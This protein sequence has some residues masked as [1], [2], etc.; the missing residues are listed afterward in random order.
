MSDTTGATGAA[1]SA[2]DLLSGATTGTTTTDGGE[3]TT[4]TDTT[5]TTAATTATKEAPTW[6]DNIDD[7]ELKGWAQNKGYREVKDLAVAHRGL[8]KLLSSEK[9]PLPKD[10]ADAD[11]WNRVYSALGRPEDKTGYKLGEIAE[12]DPDFADA[13]GDWFHEAGLSTRQAGVLA[14]KWN[15]HQEKVIAKMEADFQAK[16]GA[17]MS[18]LKTEWGPKFEANTELARRGARMLG[19]DKDAMSGVERVLGTKGMLT[20]LAKIGGGMGEDEFVDG[21][22]RKSFGMTPDQAQERL[23]SLMADKDWAA[24]YIAGDADKRAEIERLNRIISGQKAAA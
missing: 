3:T 10:E 7:P 12:A 18:D 15:A 22:T 19:W 14:E 4:T 2:A 9:L 16:S 23:K 13:A 5:G 21:E 8:E 6:V 24:K 20:A 11:G 17:E 1:T